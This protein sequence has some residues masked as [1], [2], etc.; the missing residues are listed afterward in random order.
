MPS[1]KIDSRRK[2]DPHAVRPQLPGHRRGRSERHS[3]HE[4]MLSVPSARC[5]LLGPLRR[6]SLRAFVRVG[7]DLA[8]PGVD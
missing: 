4:G 3:C 1:Q 8:G 5:L 6:L 7:K 2:E